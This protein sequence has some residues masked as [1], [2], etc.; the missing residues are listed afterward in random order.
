M[1]VGEGPFESVDKLAAENNSQNLSGE[2]EAIARVDPAL[3]IGGE[4]AGR[5]HTMDMGMMLQFLIPTMEHA[6][7]A[8]FGAQVAGITRD[9]EQGFST[10]LEQQTV[11]QLLVLQSQWGEPPRQ[12]EDD[13]DV[14][15]RQKFAAA[16]P[17]ATGRERGPD[18]WGSVDYGTS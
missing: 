16:R 8:D 14:G 15:D 12:G 9:F 5:D 6:E 7:E 4:A 3:V 18:T 11:D 1:A 17:L 2:E 10:G 13:M